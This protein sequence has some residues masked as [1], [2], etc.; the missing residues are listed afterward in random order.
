MTCATC[1]PETLTPADRQVI[2]IFQRFL[3]VVGPPGARAIPRGWVP[4]CLGLPEPPPGYDSVAV[5]AWG[6]PG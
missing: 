3:R 2:R 6:L 5:T 4:Y 1:H